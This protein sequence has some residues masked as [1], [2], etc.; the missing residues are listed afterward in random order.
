[1]PAYKSKRRFRQRRQKAR[2]Q[3]EYKWSIYTEIW[4]SAD[5]YFLIQALRIY[6]IIPKRAFIS[7]E[8]KQVFEALAF[9]NLKHK[10]FK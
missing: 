7:L 8:E 9:S 1:M 5:F 4:E 6:S 2:R 10:K 3:R